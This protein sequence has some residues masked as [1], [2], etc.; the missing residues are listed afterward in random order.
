MPMDKTPVI[1]IAVDKNL[2][3]TGC[4][5]EEHTCLLNTVDAPCAVHREFRNVQEMLID[6]LRAK[7]FEDVMGA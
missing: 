5:Q 4:L 3:V 7:T 6:A 1:S 2:F